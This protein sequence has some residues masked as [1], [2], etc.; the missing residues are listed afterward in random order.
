MNNFDVYLNNSNWTVEFEKT[1]AKSET[2]PSPRL[3]FIFRE[4]LL[5]LEGAL[6]TVEFLKAQDVHLQLIL[7]DVN[8][9][10]KISEYKP[11]FGNAAY[12]FRKILPNNHAKLNS[13]LFLLGT[14][15][16]SLLIEQNS[17]NST[18]YVGNRLEN[19]LIGLKAGIKTIYLNEDNKFSAEPNQSFV[20]QHENNFLFRDIQDIKSNFY[21]FNRK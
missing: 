20:Y 19:I 18:Y 3:K 17:K 4:H 1:K 2:K 14:Q 5:E 9:L 16:Y 21:L 8:S 10:R 13:G 11:F 7:N 6:E 12:D 15:E